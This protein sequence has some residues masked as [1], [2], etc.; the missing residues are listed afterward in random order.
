MLQLLGPS[1]G[2]IRR[3]VAHLTE[4]LRRRGW[5]VRT[6]G[7]VGVL[8]GL[9]ALDHAVEVPA[10]FDPVA[11]RRARRQLALVAGDAALVHAHGLKAGWL[12][13]SLR[14]RPPLVVT[15]HNLVLAEVAGPEAWL[16]Q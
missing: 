2:G 4:A 6:A 8:D 3:H 16:L 12:A 14:R 15:V 1:T 9:A 10:A 13:A 5:Q 7:P 11:A